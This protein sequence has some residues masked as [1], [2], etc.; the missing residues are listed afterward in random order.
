MKFQFAYFLTRIPVL[1][2]FLPVTL[3]LALIAMTLGLLL[4]ITLGLIRTFKVKGLFKLSGLYISFFR[5]TPLLVQLFIFYYG[6]P[7]VFPILSSMNAYTATFTILGLNSAAYMSETIRA[8]L[9]S[10]DKGQLEASLSVG[11]T[12]FQGLKHIVIPQAARIAIPPL[13][14]QFISL[15]KETSLGFVLGVS[16]LLARAKMGAAATYKVLEYFIA[17]AIIYWAVIIIFSHLF[18]LLETRLNK[19]Y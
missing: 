5:G 16:E 13:G 8:A 12:Y 3:S 1:L 4:G 15:L 9:N 2:K 10:V 7:E 18:T 11:M 19:G 17:V 14:N 6:L